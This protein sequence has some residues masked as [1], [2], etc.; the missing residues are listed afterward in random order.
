MCD[1]SLFCHKTISNPAKCPSWFLGG[2]FSRIS[3]S[4]PKSNEAPPPL[5]LSLAASRSRFMVKNYGGEQQ[6]FPPKRWRSTAS[7]EM[8]SDRWL[9]LSAEQ[10]TDGRS[11]RQKYWGMDMDQ[12]RR[13]TRFTGS[14]QLTIK[15][16]K[17]TKKSQFTAKR[18]TLLLFQNYEKLE[19]AILCKI[20]V[21]HNVKN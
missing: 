19:W 8:L 14:T 12:C 11:I 4:Y 16:W 1:N 21:G 7:L 10:R 2:L 18:V 5:P 20:R 13:K 9:P 6:L 17:I 3:A 15:C